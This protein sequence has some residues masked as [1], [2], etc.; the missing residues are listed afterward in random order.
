MG[1]GPY[2][3][4]R[5]L[6]GFQLIY[7]SHA[8]DRICVIGGAESWSEKRWRRKAGNIARLILEKK[9][10][11]VYCG[12][13]AGVCGF[14]AKEVLVGKGKV[15][16]WL[17]PERKPARTPRGVKVNLAEDYF[18]RMKKF[19]QNADAFLVLPGGV[20]TLDE[21]TTITALRKARLLWDPVVVAN[22]DGWFDGVIGFME[23]A[24]ELDE[25]SEEPHGLFEV[26]TSLR[27]IRLK[28]QRTRL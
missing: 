3:Y 20:G 16:A 22:W 6:P 5:D 8:V 4:G 27:D 23:G 21:L 9:W 12:H 18:D 1:M 11:M 15:S 17:V 10:E 26:C 7:G 24:L 2:P 13:D 19:T 28:L 25:Y 14:I